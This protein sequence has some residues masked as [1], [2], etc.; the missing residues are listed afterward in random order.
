MALI[1]DCQEAGVDI[2]LR[3]MG[4]TRPLVKPLPERTGVVPRKP[5]L[6]HPQPADA[7]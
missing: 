4:G 1:V 5:V 7:C 2:G 6:L 3:C